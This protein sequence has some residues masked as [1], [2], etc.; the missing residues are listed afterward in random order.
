MYYSLMI[1]TITTPCSFKT[2][3]NKFYTFYVLDKNIKG[4]ACNH[5]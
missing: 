3:S 4:V 1:D 2:D 5:N